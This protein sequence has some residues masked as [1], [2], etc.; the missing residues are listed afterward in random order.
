MT[1]T[2]TVVA[3]ASENGSLIGYATL[4]R[5]TMWK[6]EVVQHWTAETRDGVRVGL[7][8]RTA[9]EAVEAIRAEW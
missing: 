5:K 7:T 8:F 9:D 3:A 4:D 1:A 2:G 6:G